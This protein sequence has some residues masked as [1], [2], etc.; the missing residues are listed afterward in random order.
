MLDLELRLLLR[1]LAPI[2]ALDHIAL[3]RAEPLGCR[4]GEGPHWDYGKAG[5]ELDRRHRIARRRPD[6]RLLDRGVG[7][8]FIGADETG[9]ELNPGSA[10]F[11]KGQDRLAAPD[12][13][14]D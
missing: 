3:D 6:K 10:H 9:A 12:P 13:A 2:E 5:I 11:Q 7:D 4:I 14:G 8:R 1:Q